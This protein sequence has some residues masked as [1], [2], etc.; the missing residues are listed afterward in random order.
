[1]TG[2]KEGIVINQLHFNDTP[3]HIRQIQILY[4]MKTNK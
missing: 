4:N 2:N 1:M 3:D